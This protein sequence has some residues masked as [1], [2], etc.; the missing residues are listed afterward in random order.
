MVDN[1]W[2]I[3]IEGSAQKPLLWRK[4]TWTRK[5]RLRIYLPSLV[6]DR[7]FITSN[8]QE[9]VLCNALTYLLF[10][11]GAHGVA[12]LQKNLWCFSFWF[13]SH[14]LNKI[15]QDVVAQHHVFSSAAMS[16]E[17]INRED[18]AT[19][20][21]YN[22]CIRSKRLHWGSKSFMPSHSVFCLLTL[23]LGLWGI[24][25]V[26]VAFYT[27][28]KQFMR[29][30]TPK[31]FLVAADDWMSKTKVTEFQ[32]LCIHRL[33]STFGWESNFSG[34]LTWNFACPVSA[35]WFMTSTS[36]SEMLC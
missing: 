28:K 29:G 27:I 2:F 22:F 32:V 31:G 23:C 14:G 35:T 19:S 26:Q 33:K 7:S 8:L 36:T 15:I 24:K 16:Q 30:W 18:R 1:C 34:L 10:L 12:A 9:M 17:Y 21:V 13:N 6:S 4:E 11:Q 25:T 3:I 20:P 5:R